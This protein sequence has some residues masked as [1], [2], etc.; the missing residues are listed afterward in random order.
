MDNLPRGHRNRPGV[1]IRVTK[2]AIWGPSVYSNCEYM[3]F[4]MHHDR[5]FGLM[6]TIFP[7][8][9]GTVPEWLIR[10]IFHVFGPSIPN[11]DLLS[12]IDMNLFKYW[13]LG[14]AG[15]E[16]PVKIRS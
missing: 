6:W 1:V 7:G 5:I 11:S 10:Q 2:Y 4:N 15:M 8:G 14:M 12:R 16:I 9:T 3:K 13:Y